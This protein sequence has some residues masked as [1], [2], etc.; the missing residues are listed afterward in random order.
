MQCCSLAVRN[1]V[2]STVAFA[3]CVTNVT[4]QR[5]EQELGDRAYF[6]TL[7]SWRMHTMSTNLP[8]DAIARIGFFLK[9]VQGPSNSTPPRTNTPS[10]GRVVCVCIE[11]TASG[12]S[13]VGNAKPRSEL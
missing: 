10:P 9:A 8:P 5:V 2:D 7:R 13:Y 4:M 11:P 6:T 1:T 3:V 12:Q